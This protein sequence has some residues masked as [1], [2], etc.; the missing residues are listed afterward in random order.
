MFILNEITDAL[1]NGDVNTL[2]IYG[3]GGIG[4]T[5]LAK[6]IA[7]R[8]ENDKL[9]DQVVFSEVSE[10]QDIRKI[11]REIAD[12]LGLKFD[13][14][15]ESG[16]ARRLHDRL[17]KEKRILVILD[18]IWGK[19]DL[20]AAGIPHGDDHRGCKVLLTARSL[21]T[22]SRKMDS[23]KNFSVSFLK[24]EE[25]W[26]LFKK[27]AG[28]SVEGNEL[29]E[30]AR[31]VAKECAGLPVAIVTV[32]T[33][34]RD[35]NSL[36]DWKDALEQLRR[37]SSTNLMNVQPTAYKAIKLSYDKLAGEELKNIFLLIGYTAI[38]SIDD[39]LMYGMGMGLFQEERVVFHA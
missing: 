21:D 20:K 16:R 28:D 2:G 25:A 35:N 39:L 3:I 9:F 15:S 22:L 19:L 6:E 30:V 8:A 7:R 14:E 18:N 34:L 12:K 10:S 17:K 31:D 36:F 5:T 23:Q 33:A 38:A 32:A 1:K 4:K 27:M 29:K 13:E 26:S 24:E 11:Q 37:P